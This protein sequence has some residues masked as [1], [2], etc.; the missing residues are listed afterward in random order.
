VLL[1]KAFSYL[2]HPAF[3]PTLGMWLIFNADPY[4][5]NTLVPKFKWLLLIV[6]A[7][8]TCILPITFVFILKR[9]GL[10]SHLEMPERKE[11]LLPFFFTSVFFGFAFW[12]VYQ[13]PSPVIIKQL[14]A[15]MTAAVGLLFAATFIG[16]PSAHA[17][18]WAALCA[19]VLALT[20]R[21]S[22]HTG[23]FVPLTFLLWGLAA[24]SRLY[25]HK[26]SHAQI[27]G[28]TLI[29]GIPVFGMFWLNLP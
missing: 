9:R 16:K 22:A 24:S 15:G 10:I 21:W 17:A 27:L 26:H 29:G 23:W 13:S 18:A 19:A 4:L 8:H 11:R 1:A 2:L 14:F 3:A 12:M 25:L 7:L 5:Q 6:L 28:G 20:I